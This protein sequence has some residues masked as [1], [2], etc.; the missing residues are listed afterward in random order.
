MTDL[1][2]LTVLLVEDND[3]DALLVEEALSDA[4]P[5]GTVTLHRARDLAGATAALEA[6]GHDCVLLDL[7]LPDAGSGLD[8]LRSVLAVRPYAAVVVLTGR[9]DD[10]LAAAAIEFGAQDYL[11]KRA[12][13]SGGE[14]VRAIR[15]AAERVE[16]TSRL[17]T[18][19]NELAD[20]AGLAAHDL[21]GPLTSIVGIADLL[22]QTPSLPV[23]QRTAMLERIVEVGQRLGSV[24]GSMLTYAVDPGAARSVVQLDD[25]LA[26]VHPLVRPDL[27]ATGGRLEV[28]DLG[29][30]WSNEPA[31]RTVV[32]NLVAN[33]VEHR[34]DDR[35]PVVRVTSEHDDRHVVLRIEDNGPG[36]GEG[37]RE[38]VFTL[39]W[40]LDTQRSGGIG[41]GLS[42]VRR[43]VLQ[44]DGRVW[45]ED[46]ATGRGVAV[47]V[48]LP[49][50][51]T[52]V[53]PRSAPAAR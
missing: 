21:R 25:V 38:K 48:A 41:L 31:L 22:A 44:L 53:D 17:R 49:R 50:P 2:Q 23:E 11:V 52:D 32:H 27:E 12:D 5:D 26:W 24:V 29:E 37:D 51:P 28:D 45:F 33:A 10:A 13:P 35:P 47:C 3:G 19:R 20:F 8:A 4:D 40:Q 36:V 39:G 15:F 7:G 46:T 1:P 16:A 9:D 42:A 43:T 18:S 30:A 14:L 6:S 34:A